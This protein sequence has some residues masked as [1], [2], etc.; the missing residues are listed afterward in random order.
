[1]TEKAS[2]VQGCAEAALVVLYCVCARFVKT[3]LTEWELP[4]GCVGCPVSVAASLAAP[5]SVK[6]DQTMLRLCGGYSGC[7]VATC[8]YLVSKMADSNCC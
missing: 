2:Q 5:H 1:M 7:I 6:A 4:P 8:S 3:I